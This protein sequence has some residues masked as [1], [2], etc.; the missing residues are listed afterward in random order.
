MEVEHKIVMIGNVVRER[1]FLGDDSVIPRSQQLAT[2]LNNMAKDGWRLA[3]CASEEMIFTRQ[4]TP[5][6]RASTV[7][8]TVEAVLDGLIKAEFCKE[9]FNIRDF[10][11]IATEAL[12]DMHAGVDEGEPP[13]A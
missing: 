4:Q 12:T 3:G 2:Y 10:R 5:P 9:T 7:K 1:E 13:P 11:K 8:E 6:F